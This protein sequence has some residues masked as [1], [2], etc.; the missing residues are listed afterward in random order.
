MSSYNEFYK[1]NALSKHIVGG[2]DSL[3]NCDVHTDIGT[4]QAQYALAADATSGVPTEPCVQCTSAVGTEYFFSTTTG[5]QWKRNAS[6]GAYTA[7]TANANTTGHKGCQYYN[8]KI[9]YWTATKFGYFTAETEASRNDSKGTFSNSNG[10]ASCEENLT[11]YITDG[12]Y[13]ASYNSSDAF[14]ANALDIPAQYTGSAI[15]PDGFTNIL[16]GTIISS[17]VHSCRGFLWDTYSDSFTLS[18]ELPEIGINCFINCDEVILAQC[19]TTGKLYQWTGQTFAI[20]E[21]ELRGETTTTGHQN[22]VVLNSRPLIAVGTKIYSIYRKNNT[23]PRVVVQEYTA[24]GAITSLGVS[25]SAL[26][27]ST[28]TGVN[29]ISANRATATIDTCEDPGRFNQVIVD[30]QSYPAG[31]GISTKINGG[32]WTAQTE[33]IDTINQKVYFDGGLANVNYIQSRITLTP[34]GATSPVISNITIQ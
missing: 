5:K 11:L 30:Y 31:I 14:T 19:G 26:I 1:G 34:S 12:K 28:A 22:S 13:T 20:W 32:A 9:C 8:G 4:I 25:G 29:L 3:V 7:L 18:D 10:Y 21:N 33:I 23:L 15:T 27:V 6:T 16:I 17:T 2:F 24:T